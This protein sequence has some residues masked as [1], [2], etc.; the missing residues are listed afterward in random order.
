M[1]NSM[2]STSTISRGERPPHALGTRRE[3]EN[4]GAQAPEQA[5]CRWPDSPAHAFAPT[6]LLSQ[7]KRP[8]G[9]AS[10]CFGAGASS[11]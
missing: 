8:Y 9:S 10:G 6:G 11:A 3:T 2:D 4:A 5:P 7:G 1:D